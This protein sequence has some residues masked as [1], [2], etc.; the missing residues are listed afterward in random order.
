MSARVLIV[1]DL[2]ANRRLLEARL[3]SEYYNVITATRGEEAVQKARREQPDII[4]LDVM[5]PGGIDGFEACRRIKSAPDTRHIPV[6][7]V[8]TLA[9]RESRM[10]GL[11]AGAEDLLTKPFDD[12]HLLARVKSLVS[13]KLVTD[14]LR[15]REARS[16][17]LGVIDQL[18]A[19]D[20]LEAHRVIA[21]HVLVIE[22]SAIQARRIKT[23]LSVEHRVYDFTAPDAGAASP[24]LAIVSTVARAF[25]GLRVIAGLRADERTRHLPVLAIIDPDDRGRAL[26]ALEVGAH[27]IITRPVDEEE[28]CAR[29]RTLIKR[30]RYM[31]LLRR[32]LDQ[33][34]ELAVIDQLTGLFNRRFLFSQLEP[35]VRRAECGG[36]IVSV[37]ILDID[38][39]KK[40]NDGFGHD[41]GD[42]VLKEFAARIGSNARPG[43]YACRYGGEEF[44]MILPGTTGDEACIAGERIRRTVSGAPFT[45]SN[46]SEPIDVTVSI[47]V[48]AFTGGDSAESLIKRADEALYEAKRSGRNRVVGRAAPAAA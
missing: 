2:E 37:L 35:L 25:D 11:R 17:A 10:R 29:A 24:D 18:N 33:S 26:R 32:R 16:R 3:K 28:L 22:D 20:P 6:V 14:E 45:V 7:M 15:A 48:S 41:V 21:G 47:G 31:D 36:D 40:I 13:L 9:D 5:M 19:P 42:A 46:L 30:K 23:T 43:D 12:V 1:D 34:I 4:L 39:F 8:T 44:C 38:H 27:D